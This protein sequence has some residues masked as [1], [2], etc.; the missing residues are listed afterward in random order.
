MNEKRKN[1]RYQI[2]KSHNISFIINEYTYLEPLNISLSGLSFKTN[3][4]NL[5][6]NNKTFLIKIM[7]SD[8]NIILNCEIIWNLYDSYG[9]KFINIDKNNLIKLKK[10]TNEIK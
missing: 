1:K 9:V 6:K 4:M 8:T 7:T 3:N 2:L 10:I 5:L